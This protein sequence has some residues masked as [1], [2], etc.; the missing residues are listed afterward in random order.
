MSV[1]AWRVIPRTG[2]TGRLLL[3]ADQAMYKVKKA[4]GKGVL[5]G[6]EL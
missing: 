6:Y 5:F 3:K 1:S 2:V 4:G